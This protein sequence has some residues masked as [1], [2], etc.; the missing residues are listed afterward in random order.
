MWFVTVEAIL[1]CRVMRLLLFDFF[2]DILMTGVTEARSLGYKQSF[3]LGLVG[4]MTHGTVPLDERHVFRCGILEALV[5]FVAVGT[6]LDLGLHQHTGGIAAVGIVAGHAFT[7]LEGFMVG[8]VY[9]GLHHL[10]V[11]V[12]TEFR[13]SS[14]EKFCICTGVSFMAGETFATDHRLVGIGLFELD[15]CIRV[16]GIAELIDTIYRHGGEVGT[17]GIV[18]GLTLPPLE[19]LM[20][21]FAFQGVFSLG[22][23]LIAEIGAFFVYQSLESGSMRLV[24]RQTALGTINRS[25][26]VCHFVCHA[27]VA[28]EA[29]RIAVPGHQFGILG[30]VRIM[31][32][33]TVTTFE[34]SMLDSAACRERWH[35]MALQTKR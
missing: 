32:A 13:T 5:W 12:V 21:S 17:V 3:Q 27:L 19:W 34:W 22:V 35:F 2:L 18:A 28:A 20:D 1:L 24:T 14:L 31:A 23:T 6:D 30:G 25:M 29:K 33:E 15:F 16:A 11:T 7:T 10:R 8:T 4:I 26:L 9:F